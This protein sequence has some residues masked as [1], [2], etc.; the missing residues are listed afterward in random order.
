[1]FCLHLFRHVRSDGWT[2]YHD[3]TIGWWDVRGPLG[4]KKIGWM[5]SAAVATSGVQWAG[6]RKGGETAGRVLCCPFTIKEDDKVID[7]CCVLRIFP[8]VKLQVAAWNV[9]GGFSAECKSRPWLDFFLRLL[10]MCRLHK[11]SSNKQRN[12]QKK[13]VGAA[14]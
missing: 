13:L 5:Q 11:R 2:Q 1:M 6:G 4:K 3:G 7:Q 14:V 12:Q 9:A 8:T 10:W